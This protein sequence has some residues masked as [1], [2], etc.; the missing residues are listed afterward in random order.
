M[1]SK[2]ATALGRTLMQGE[3]DIYARFAILFAVAV[4]SVVAFYMSIIATIGLLAEEAGAVG[5]GQQW[6]SYL[7]LAIVGIGGLLPIL[8]FIVSDLPDL[9]R[10]IFE[11]NLD[12]LVMGVA[13]AIS[14]IILLVV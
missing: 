7:A 2:A 13:L 12:R 14:C 6:P 1:I 5:T 8:R 10:R 3:I 4:A 11:Q 9:G